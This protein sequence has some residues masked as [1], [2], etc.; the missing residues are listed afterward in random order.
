MA[1]AIRCLWR[2]T[3]QRGLFQLHGSVLYHRKYANRRVSLLRTEISFNSIAAQTTRSKPILRR[4]LRR[5]RCMPPHKATSDPLRRFYGSLSAN[6]S[7]FYCAMGHEVGQSYAWPLMVGDGS[8]HW[9]GFKATLWVVEQWS[10][11]FVGHQMQP[12]IANRDGHLEGVR[13][14]VAHGSWLVIVL[15]SLILWYGFKPRLRCFQFR[16]IERMDHSRLV[17]MQLRSTLC[18]YRTALNK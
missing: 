8:G 14:I 4:H 7:N 10:K 11:N 5:L 13:L 2:I 16:N 12:P 18:N 17:S 3:L 9:G 1:M 6:D 15:V